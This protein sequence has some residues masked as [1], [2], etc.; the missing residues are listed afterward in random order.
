LVI[1]YSIAVFITFILSQVG[2]VRHWWKSKTKIKDW[3]KKLII[4][5]V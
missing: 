2:M 3:K 1:F 5:G 4:N